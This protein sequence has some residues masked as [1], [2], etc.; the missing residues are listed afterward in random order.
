MGRRK[1][2]RGDTMEWKEKVWEVCR[3]NLHVTVLTESSQGT[4]TVAAWHNEHLD[5]IKT[6]RYRNT[7]AIVFKPGAATNSSERVGNESQPNKE[8]PIY[9]GLPPLLKVRGEES[10]VKGLNLSK[11]YGSL[12]LAEIG[13]HP[14]HLK[15]QR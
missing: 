2:E 8:P 7:A 13:I 3:R 10:K 5:E 4:P 14:H 12:I 9:A 1:H 11:L 15:A 6:V